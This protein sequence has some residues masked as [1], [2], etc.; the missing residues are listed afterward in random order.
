MGEGEEHSK[1]EKQGG[2]EQMN[3]KYSIVF[4]KLETHQ[5]SRRERDKPGFPVPG[6]HRLS[7]GSPVPSLG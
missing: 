3:V 5:R 2:L 7:L 4:R 6:G 1:K